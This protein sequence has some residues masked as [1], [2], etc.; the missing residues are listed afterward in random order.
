MTAPRSA[1][2]RA[3]VMF[4]Q[5]LGDAALR[6]ALADSPNPM[7]RAL[8]AWLDLLGEQVEPG[9]P[10]EDLP[11]GCGS[12]EAFCARVERARAFVRLGWKAQ[13]VPP[14]GRARNWGW[15]R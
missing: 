7:C 3:Q 5:L 11:P 10:V 4:V 8:A 1:A 14:E 12:Y 15:E 9:R 2:E 13:P 6:R